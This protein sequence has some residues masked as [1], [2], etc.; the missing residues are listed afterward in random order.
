ME[1]NVIENIIGKG[2]NTDDKYY[3]LFPQCFLP[4]SDKHNYLGHI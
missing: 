1:K 3:P 2:T 4:L